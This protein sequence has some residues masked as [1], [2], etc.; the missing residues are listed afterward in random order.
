MLTNIWKYGGENHLQYYIWYIIFI[1]YDIVY[2]EHDDNKTDNNLH[3]RDDPDSND[4]S[5][6]SNDDHIIH[7][8]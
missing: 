4:K 1:T 6:I 8:V 3:G 7:P 5:K 2:D